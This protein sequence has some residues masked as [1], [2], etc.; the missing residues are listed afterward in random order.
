M[1]RSA[2]AIEDTPLLAGEMTIQFSVR[3]EYTF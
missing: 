3:V 1:A 2:K